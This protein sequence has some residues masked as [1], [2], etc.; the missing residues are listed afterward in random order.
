MLTNTK[1]YIKEVL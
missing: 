1:S